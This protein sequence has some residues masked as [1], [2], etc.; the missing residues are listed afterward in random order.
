[1]TRSKDGGKTWSEP[2]PTVGVQGKMPDLWETPDGRL[3]LVVGCE[4][5]ADGSEIYRKRDRRTFNVLFISDD[6]GATW[7]RDVEIPPLDDVTEAI[8]ADEPTMVPLGGGRYFVAS[9]VIDR[10]AERVGHPV[11]WDYYFSLQ[12]TILAPR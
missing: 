2:R 1:M 8:P 5:N 9:Q 12:A 10:G 7:R 6:A 4:G 3:L 11:D